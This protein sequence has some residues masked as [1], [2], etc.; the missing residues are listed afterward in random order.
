MLKAAPYQAGLSSGLR[1]ETAYSRW[2][3][4]ITL[5]QTEHPQTKDLD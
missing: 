1:C 3:R 5:A 2:L 4:A